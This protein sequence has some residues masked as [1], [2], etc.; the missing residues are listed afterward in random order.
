MGHAGRAGRP[1]GGAGRPRGGAA[2]QTHESRCILVYKTYMGGGKK[3]MGG[4][5]IWWWHGLFV[6]RGGNFIGEVARP[7][8][9]QVSIS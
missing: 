3:A 4:G 7:W 5:K 2:R 9:N 1:R 8:Q 6:L